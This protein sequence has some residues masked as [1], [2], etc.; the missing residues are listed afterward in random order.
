MKLNLFRSKASGA[1]GLADYFD[2]FQKEEDN[3]KRS[4]Q[5]III[6]LRLEDKLMNI[7]N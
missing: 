7:S 2:K 5:K 6:K 1:V 3:S 4:E